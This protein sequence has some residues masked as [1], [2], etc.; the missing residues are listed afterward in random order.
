MPI[1]AKLLLYPSPL[2]APAY[3]PTNSVG[4]FPLLHILANA[5]YLCSFDDGPSDGYE[6]YLT[7]VSVCIFL[8]IS[9]AEHLFKR[10]RSD[11]SLSRV[12]LFATLWIAARQASLYITKALLI[13]DESITN[14]YIFQF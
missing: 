13:V 8:M 5:C 2:A 3:N 7:V 4:G 12:R 1:R 6:V 14:W 9:D 10:I 11:Q